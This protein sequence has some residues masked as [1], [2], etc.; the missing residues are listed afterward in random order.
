MVEVA[1]TNHGSGWPSKAEDVSGGGD[2]D[3]AK[4]MFLGGPNVLCTLSIY[5]T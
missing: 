5:T 3:G 4:N 2:N 1:G